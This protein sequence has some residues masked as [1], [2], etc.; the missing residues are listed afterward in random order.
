ML[1]ANLFWYCNAT[2][3]FTHEGGATWCNFVVVVVAGAIAVTNVKLMSQFYSLLRSSAGQGKLMM[4][5]R[6]M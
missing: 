4:R 5:V 3:T 2:N 1:A 6:V